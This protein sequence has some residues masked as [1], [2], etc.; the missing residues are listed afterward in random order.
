[1]KTLKVGIV[2]LGKIGRA[3]LA[4][5]RAS[6]GAE[7]AAIAV[8]GGP[9]ATERGHALCDSYGI[10]KFY[11]DWCDLLSDPGIDV[12]HDCAPN[13]EHFAINR[14]AMMAGKAILSEK[15]LTVDPA[16]SEELA[17]LAK[18]RN[19][20]TAVNFVYRHYGALQKLRDIV[21]SG[22]LGAIYAVRGAYLQDWLLRES[23]WDW[24]V[25]S[26]V[27]GPSRAMADIGSHWC[28]LARFLLGREVS[29]VCADLATFLPYRLKPAAGGATWVS[30]AEDSPNAAGSPGA[31]GRA[32]RVA[33]DT[34]D[35]GSAL[36]RFSG[37]ARG[38]FTVSQVSAGAKAGLAIAVDGS[39][40]SALWEH[41]RAGK[42]VIRR[43]GQ[44]EEVLDF[45]GELVAD[46]QRSMIASFYERVR[47][48][49]E[50]PAVEAARPAA[51]DAARP[52]ADFGDGHAAVRIVDAVLKSAK[53]G[54]WIRIE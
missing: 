28:D 11:A 17:Q 24:R 9:G 19:V 26:A 39:D 2:G 27:G 45:G 14:G 8:R 36:L 34:E 23:D 18:S 30:G 37:G 13:L 50:G 42:L 48:C 7:V 46:A 47:A 52:Y 53:S 1:M 3:Q 29:E 38:C 15:P 5:I 33:V 16:E 4:A 31:A 51:L 22:G 12:V 54:T 40:A 32:E 41:A 10:P 25:D 43:R 35:Y 49:I 44:R 6:G 21:A 20:S